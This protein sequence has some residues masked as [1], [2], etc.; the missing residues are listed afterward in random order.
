MM[1]GQRKKPA[2]SPLLGFDLSSKPCLS[3]ALDLREAVPALFQF[4]KRGERVAK[5][6]LGTKRICPE[7][8]KKF[9]DLGRDPVVSPYTGIAYPLSSFDLPSKKSKPDEEKVEKPK[10]ETETAE[11]EDTGDVEVVSLEE[12][13]PA[14]TASDNDDDD[15]DES[16]DVIPDI[17][18]TDIDG[19]DVS[20]SDDDTF[21]DEDD[22]NDD[23]A[24]GVVTGRDDDD[25]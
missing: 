10:E 3:G 4:P 7:T 8:G 14:D 22:E 19:D 2:K 17:D 9:Y 13:E 1:V 23:P 11:T 25:S 12:A 21:L 16:D 20:A 15:D 5:K 18:T 6:Q 24:V